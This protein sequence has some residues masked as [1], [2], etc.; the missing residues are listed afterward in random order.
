MKKN[1]ANN[2]TGFRIL[3][4]I[5]LLFLSSDSVGFAVVYLLCGVSDMADGL[6]AR[7]TNSETAF[8][9]KFDSV[10]DIVFLA[11]GLIRFLPIIHLPKW[12]WICITMIAAIRISNLIT[13]VIRKKKLITLHTVMNKTTG[14]L[15]FLLPMTLNFIEAE[16]TCAAVCAVAAFASL[17]EGYYIW[18]R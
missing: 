15:L 9:A 2:I 12:L 4:S 16:Y 1:I 18:K 7:K 8:G 6:V 13:G 11:V 5:L 14:V 3:C 17:Q 10:A